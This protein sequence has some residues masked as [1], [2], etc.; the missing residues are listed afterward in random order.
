MARNRLPPELKYIYR[1]EHPESRI[2][3]WQVL[4]TRGLER[5]ICCYFGD[6]AYGGKEASF[7]EA[8]AFRDQILANHAPPEPATPPLAGRYL[9]VANKPSELIGIRIALAIPKRKGLH[10]V[11]NWTGYARIGG[12]LINRSFAMTKWGYEA[13]FWN[14]AQHRHNLTGQPLPASLPAPPPYIVEWAE[15]MAEFGIDVFR[16]S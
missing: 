15:Q 3:G 14:A 13:A 10:P 12:K 1:Q 8:K 9:R 4:Y 7:I 16:A 6:K 2:F 11:Y 5:E